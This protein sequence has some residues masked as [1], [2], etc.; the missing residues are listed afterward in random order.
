MASRRIYKGL[1]C[2]DNCG[3]HRAGDTVF[4]TTLNQLCFYNGTAWQKIT[5][6]TM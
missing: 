6:A 4:N 2:K 1:P 5:S 3:G